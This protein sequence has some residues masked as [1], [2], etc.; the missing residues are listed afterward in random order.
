MM[1]V[2]VK[3]QAAAQRDRVTSPR[4]L[5]RIV[6]ALERLSPR[7]AGVVL[8]EGPAAQG[9]E[10]ERVQTPLF[11]MDSDPVDLPFALVAEKD[12]EED[13]GRSSEHEGIGHGNENEGHW[14]RERE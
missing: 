1:E 5:E 13:S 12:S 6:E 11:L 10:A 14:A 9:M 2:L 3:E 8:T 4:L 7:R